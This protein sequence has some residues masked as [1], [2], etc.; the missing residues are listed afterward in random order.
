GIEIVNSNPSATLAQLKEQLAP[1]LHE[2][3]QSTRKATHE[4]VDSWVADEKK[5]SSDMPEAER[6]L[7]EKIADDATNGKYPDY[8]PRIKPVN[9]GKTYGADGAV[10]I[11]NTTYD[12]LPG[13]WQADNQQAGENILN[14]LIK[15]KNTDGK[16]VS[17]AYNAIASTVSSDS[18]DFLSK[19]G[20][21]FNQSGNSIASNDPLV[22]A[23]AREFNK[24]KARTGVSYSNELQLAII[25]ETARDLQEKK[26]T[27]TDLYK[28]VLSKNPGPKD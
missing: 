18:H 9:G 8:L 20:S 1:V 2:S 10:D 4:M 23:A 15:Q 21:L 16:I 26:E 7:F 5:R 22:L 14:V 12:K 19:A 11:A 17:N 25:A 6:S 27:A 13:Y 28:K 24:W 3:W